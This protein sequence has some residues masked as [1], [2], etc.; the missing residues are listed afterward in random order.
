MILGF[1]EQFKPKIL[2]GTKIHTLRVDKNKRWQKGK[3][4]HFA[5]GQRTKNYN[6]FMSGV[7][8]FN[9]AVVLKPVERKIYVGL[10]GKVGLLPKSQHETLAIR[11]GFDSLDKFWKF[12]N[13]TF[14]GVI[15][16]WTDIPPYS[17]VFKTH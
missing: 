9:Q 13:K 11:D 16:H 5:T 12:F 4:I 1:K 2:D 8:T 14:F 3:K 15:V 17:P 6:Q 10:N 7:C